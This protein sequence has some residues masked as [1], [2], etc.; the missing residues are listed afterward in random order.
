MRLV[1]GAF[2]AGGDVAFSSRTE[3]NTNF[4]RLIDVMLSQSARDAGFYPIVATHDVL[5]QHGP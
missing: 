4:H 5:S 2:A 3:I 1:K